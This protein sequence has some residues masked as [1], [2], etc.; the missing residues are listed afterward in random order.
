[1]QQT[2]VWKPWYTAGV[3]TLR[4]S[5]DANGIHATSH[6]MQVIKGNSIVAN[7]LIDCDTRWRFRRLWLKVDN[8]GQR[9][10]CLHRDLR[11]NWL[12]DGQPRPD[13]LDC[14]HVMLSASPF[15]HTPPLQRSALETGQSDEMQVAYIDMLSLKIE[16]RQ[17]RYQCLRRRPG[18]TLYRSQAEGSP[19]TE[20]CVDDQALL[21]KANEHYL[22]LSQ[23]DLK[24]SALV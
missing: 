24:V 14:Q 4:L 13:L 2:L 12:L 18:E 5:Q 1:M 16:P 17:Q 23:R 8:H 22:R 21:L 9:S 10:L 7:Y 6:L 3:E 15:T 19:Q 11:G 20:L